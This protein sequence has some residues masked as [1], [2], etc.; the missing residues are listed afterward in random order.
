MQKIS[1]Y[2]IATGNLECSGFVD[3]E[4]MAQFVKLR[5]NLSFDIPAV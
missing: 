4:G 3:G 2:N 5:A 1:R